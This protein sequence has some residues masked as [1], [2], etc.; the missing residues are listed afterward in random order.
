V[1]K[2]GV[3]IADERTIARGLRPA[4]QDRPLAVDER[5]V[6]WLQNDEAGDPWLRSLP[7]GP[8]QGRASTQK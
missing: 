2:E 1:N 6:L 5:R 8:A 7:L 4:T 3:S